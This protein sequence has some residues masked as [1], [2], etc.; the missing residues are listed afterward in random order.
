[1]T[2]NNEIEINNTITWLKKQRDGLI[3]GDYRNI[4]YNLYQKILSQ[5]TSAPP[6]ILNN[7]VD[8]VSLYYRNEYQILEFCKALEELGYIEI[9]ESSDE[10]AITI[11]KPID[12]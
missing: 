6:C 2:Q 1:M 9:C 5:S 7:L 12:F 10:L 8:T 3:V 11:L 4:L